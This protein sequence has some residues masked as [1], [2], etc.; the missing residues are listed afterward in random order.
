MAEA[1]P[2]PTASPSLAHL[3]HDLVL[4]SQ[5]LLPTSSPA[6]DERPLALTD[7]DL[8]DLATALNTFLHTQFKRQG[9]QG[10]GAGQTFEGC[11]PF[12][13]AVLRPLCITTPLRSRLHQRRQRCAVML[14]DRGHRHRAEYLV[15]VRWVPFLL[16]LATFAEYNA[17]SLQREVSDIRRSWRRRHLPLARRLRDHRCELYRHPDRQRHDR[18][19]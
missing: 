17:Y 13:S 14:S 19:V 1:T 12:P 18:C 8:H 9:T 11:E 15:K 5:R 16:P 7:G 3:L 4:P 10:T 6:L 2:R